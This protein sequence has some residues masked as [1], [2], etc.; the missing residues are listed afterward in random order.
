M[1]HHLELGKQ[2]E[3]IAV[4]YLSKKGYTIRERN[5]RYSRAEIDIIAQQNTILVF[6]EVKAR[7]TSIFGVPEIFVDQKKMR[8]MVDAATVY[9]DSHNF[10]GEFRFDILAIIIKSREEYSLKHIEDAFFPG[11]E[12]F[13]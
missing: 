2:G 11:I 7:S 5:W 4:R 1:K 12:G 10:I 13:M 8:L 6:C 3:S 9:M